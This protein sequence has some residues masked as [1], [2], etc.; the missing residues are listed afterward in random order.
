MQLQLVAISISILGLF[1]SPE[2]VHK[3]LEAQYAKNPDKC[4]SLAK[5]WS[6]NKERQAE[7]FYFLSKIYFDKHLEDKK[8]ST[9]ALNLGRSLSYALKLQKSDTSFLFS[10]PEWNAFRLELEKKADSLVANLEEEGLADRAQILQVRLIKLENEKPVNLKEIESTKI[11]ETLKLG[12]RENGQFFG[13]PLGDENVPSYNESAEKELVA[14]INKARKEKGMG[15]LIWDED[16]A[17][18]ARYHACDLATQNYFTHN[19]YDSI[20]GKLVEIGG[21]FERIRKFYTKG[22]VNSENLA[23]GNEKAE[24]TYNQWY[25]SPGHYQNMFYAASKKVGIGV[26]YDENS[27][28]GYY[29]AFCTALE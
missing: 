18:A 23:A 5:K 26:F 15:E 13:M 16:L 14:I 7:S 29:W 3:R 8:L 17:R 12:R 24:H 11:D 27:S 9:Q 20:N 10:A 19:T 22:F 6:S 4:I 21:T 25:N 28:Y 2:R 1:Y